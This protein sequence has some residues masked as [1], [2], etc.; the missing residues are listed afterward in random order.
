MNIRALIAMETVA[1]PVGLNVLDVWRALLLA[2]LVMMIFGLMVWMQNLSR[3]HVR[4]QSEKR[5]A[6]RNLHRSR[7]EAAAQRDE[8]LDA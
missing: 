3:D 4:R 6:L 7:I 1:L 5:L 8:L 2:L